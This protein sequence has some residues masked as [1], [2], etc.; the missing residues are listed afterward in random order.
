MQGLCAL[1]TCH[2]PRSKFDRTLGHRPFRPIAREFLRSQGEINAGASCSKN[3]Y[4]NR[5]CSDDDQ[6]NS[7]AGL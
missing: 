2:E 7:G 5:K 4:S 6:I 1:L 3:K